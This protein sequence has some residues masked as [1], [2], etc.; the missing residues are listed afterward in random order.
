[1]VPVG[2]CSSNVTMARLLAR[3]GV[4]VREFRYPVAAAD[5]PVAMRREMDHFCSLFGVSRPRLEQT[6][7]ELAGVRRTLQEVDD[8]NWR[9]RRLSGSAA[10][11]LLLQSTDMGGDPVL[12]QRRLEKA[13]WEHRDAPPRTDGPL[14]GLFGVPTILGGLAE[15]LERC[16]AHVGLCETEYDF[17]MLPPSASPEEHYLAYA[18]PYGIH[19]RLEKYVRLARARRLDGVV[20][21]QQSFCHHNLENARV[22]AALSHLPTLVVEGDVP[23]EVSPRDALRLEGFAEV[24]GRRLA[25]RP[26]PG[27]VGARPPAATGRLAMGLDLGSRFAKVMVQG[28]DRRLS[29]ALDTVE[30]YRRFAT[31]GEGDHS[32]D[33]EALLRELGVAR[34]D[35]DE[36]VAV[37]TGYGRHLVRFANARVIP[38]LAAHA[39]GAASQVDDD[40]F[41]L[42]DLGGQDTKALVVF[43]GRVAQFV[44]NDKCAAGSG[45][46]VENMARLLGLPVEEV[47]GHHRD[48]VALTNLCATFGESEVIGRVVEGA[49]SPS[50]CAGIMGSV[51]QRTAGLALRLDIPEGVRTYLAGGLAGSRALAVLLQSLLPTEEVCPL[52]EPRFN[53]ALGCLTEC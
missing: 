8:L 37:S 39:A 36:I 26:R 13:I 12:F 29:L 4:E 40:R 6:F 20:L 32:V 48:P 16:G 3:S 44:M 45:R 28:R 47:M 35:G 1:V 24:L 18:Y 43:E 49:S 19:R 30:F 10:R 21:Y 46:Y 23:G 15:A 53:G 27:A 5:P 11:M 52:P 25:P 9:E 17:A 22:E 7:E 42:L 38:E 50:I 31:P 2:D 51:A 33:L 34:S 14:V 41:L